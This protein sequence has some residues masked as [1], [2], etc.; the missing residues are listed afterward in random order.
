MLYEDL[1]PFGSRLYDLHSAQAAY[2][3]AA[4]AGSKKKDGSGY[5]PEDFSFFDHAPKTQPQEDARTRLLKVASQMGA[6]VVKRGDD[7]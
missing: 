3:S 5:S 1:E 2:L 4:L 7:R 6:K